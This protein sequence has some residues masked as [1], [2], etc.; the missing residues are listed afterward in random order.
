[1][2]DKFGAAF[3]PSLASLMISLLLLSLEEGLPLKALMGL[4]KAQ[5]Q[6]L[7]LL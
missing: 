2:A 4:A 6:L 5:P 3:L 1:M 7:P